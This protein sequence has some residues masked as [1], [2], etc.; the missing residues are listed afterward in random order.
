[1][2][3]R[4][5]ARIREMLVCLFVFVSMFLCLFKF[6]NI[7]QFG[8]FNDNKLMSGYRIFFVETGDNGQ[9]RIV[10]SSAI[11]TTEPLNLPD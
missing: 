7:T 8:M 2:Q 5:A 4:Q 3:T 11:L 9:R 1:M 10:F 6:C